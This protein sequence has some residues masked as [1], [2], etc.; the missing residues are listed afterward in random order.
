[1][2]VFKGNAAKRLALEAGGVPRA[3]DLFIETPTRKVFVSFV[4]GLFEDFTEGQ[5][6]V[7]VLSWKNPARVASTGNLNLSAMPAAV[8]GV[9]LASG[10]S[11][12]AKD[13]TLGE[14]N[15]LYTFN[16]VGVAAT[17]R[18][19]ANTS[20]K[21]KSGAAMMI[22]EG[23]VNADMGFQITT[24]NPIT[25]GTTALTL[26]RFT[27]VV[28]AEGFP[29]GHFNGAVVT[30]V[31]VTSIKVGTSGKTTSLRDKDDTFD[32]SFSGEL[33]AIIT[34][35]GKGGLDT[36]AEAANTWYF[37]HVIGDSN[38]VNA[39]DVVLSLS[40]TAPT[41]P[42]G[43]DKSRRVGP[44]RNNASSN[45]LK[46]N[47][48]GAGR[49]RRYVY[50]ETRATVQVLTSG[51]ATTFTTISLA[52]FVPPTSEWSILSCSVEQSSAAGGAQLRLRTTGDSVSEANAIIRLAE[53]SDD[54]SPSSEANWA[55]VEV[56]TDSSQQI[57]YAQL[58]AGDDADIYVQGFIDEV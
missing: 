16:G 12:L 30:W 9:T 32:I 54:S 7:D 56:E 38:G 17:R 6:A 46:F 47:Q 44:T 14:E 23:T 39:P 8:D 19:D 52:N 20:A 57:D 2:I 58:G 31:S 15:F 50:D 13:Q 53:S 42:A 37:L 24:N 22:E 49:N 18:L 45:L 51:S 11:F 28:D 35:A 43:Y 36:G 1:M 10:E 26:T 27:A 55:S 4:D 21:V 40:A 34:V 33:T 29:P 5:S 3:R 41:L 25:L 48:R